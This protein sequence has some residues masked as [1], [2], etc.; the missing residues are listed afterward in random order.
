MGLT[1]PPIVTERK[2][3]ANQQ[4]A[5]HSTGPRTE[6]GKQNS[7]LNGLVHGLYSQTRTYEAM[8]ALG[9]NPLE[10]ERQ[11]A[12]LQRTWGFGLDPLMDVEI[13][14]LAWQLWRK[15]R[16][17]RFRDAM[18]VARKEQAD[19]KGCR[20]EREYLRD[21]VDDQEA[22]RI[23]LRRLKDSP[24]AFEQTLVM[25]QLLKEDV[26]RRD[27]AHDHVDHML[28]LYGEEPT[29]R[30]LAIRNM[31]RELAH[32][33]EEKMGWSAKKQ[34]EV[35]LAAIQQ[36]Q[37]EVEAEYALFRRDHIEL[38]PWVRGAM[39]A[40]D[41]ES[42][43]IIREAASLDR[44][45]DRKIKL[46]MGLRKDLRQQL[47]WEAEMR[48]QV[49]GV[50]C[51]EAEAEGGSQEAEAGSQ[52]AEAEGSGQTSGVRGQEAP[53]GSG[54]GSDENP[55]TGPTERRA[56]TSKVTRSANATKPAGVGTD[57]T[58]T[59]GTGTDGEGR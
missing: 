53:E 38:T 37:Q 34:R 41:K 27:F 48:D 52:K 47:Q 16:V 44:A 4:N 30:G 11:R 31:F 58:G 13:D 54:T 42:K 24:A 40:A 28:Y 35:L 32:P 21:T 3:T 20:R 26:Q 59:D 39:L 7:S 51:Q 46:L 5:Q 15:Q 23:G 2:A 55:A 9:E 43:W 50:G 29:E 49:P 1:K 36:E 19:T 33:E 57:G 17:E 12:S 25:L 18:L 22:R 14:E 45:I 6:A 8:I 10:F 56:R